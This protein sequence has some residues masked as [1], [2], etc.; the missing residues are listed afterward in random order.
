MIT[1]EYRHLRRIR[2]RGLTT[3]LVNPNVATVQ[4]TRVF[5]DRVYL[6]PIKPE[7]LEMVIERE[8]PDAIAC[9]FG[10]QTALSACINLNDLGIL[11]KY[12][13]KVLGTPIEGIRSALSRQ[14]F[15][16][17]MNK[18]GIPVLPSKTTYSL[19]EALSAARELG[20]PVLARVS[21]NLG[22]A[23]AFVAHNDDELISKY[24]KALAMSEIKE[25]LIE[26][27]IG[28]WKEIEFEVMRDKYGGESVAVV[29]MENIDPPMG[30]HTGDSV[31]VAPC[32]TLT[33]DEYQR[34]RLISIGVANAINLI[35]ECNVQVAIN[36]RGGPRCTS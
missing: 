18:H 29:C 21:F 4:T 28:G 22:G 15:K 26:K 20:Y 14:L 12:G 17:L 23:G 6:V 1:R 27:Y 11:S 13:I 36:P 5:A 19:N 35:G 2:R 7:F 16:D 30:V 24:H 34:A 10:G 32:L 31:V 8:R 9:G 3:V 33:N 25:V